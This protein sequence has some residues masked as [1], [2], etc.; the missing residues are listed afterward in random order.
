M[1]EVQTAASQSHLED[2][3]VWS[4]QESMKR[5]G[6]VLFSCDKRGM[7]GSILAWGPVWI[8]LL[9]KA[10]K[11]CNMKH[12]NTCKEAW[13]YQLL[14]K[15]EVG[16]PNPP[17]WNGAAWA[18]RMGLIRTRV[19]CFQALR[20]TER[21]CWKYISVHTEHRLHYDWLQLIPT[22]PIQIVLLSESCH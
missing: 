22:A 17:G 19:L 1:E 7:T 6:E 5:Q 21:M 2:E 3:A 4:E 8:F 18:P 13:S 15:A 11:H 16:P 14:G 9:W 12:S 10:F 20:A